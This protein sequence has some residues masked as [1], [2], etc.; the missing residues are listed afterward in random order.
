[1]GDLG[2][3][4]GYGIADWFGDVVRALNMV[5]HSALVMKKKSNQ[6]FSL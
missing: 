2:L 4:G 6:R 3:E 5:E 1:M